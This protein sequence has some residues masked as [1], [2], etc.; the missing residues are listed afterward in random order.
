[1]L[2]A[3]RARDVTA[4]EA[5]LLAAGVPLMATAVRALGTAVAGLLRQRCGRVVGTSVAVLVG[6][7][8]NGADA[9]LAGAELAR[10]GVAVIAI[11]AGSR[12]HDGAARAAHRTGITLLAPGAA[13]LA[14]AA[15]CDVVLD[16]VTGIGADGPLRGAGLDVVVGL[17]AALEA[18]PRPDRPLV[19][20]VDVP[21]GIGVDD[22][23]VAG[24][25]LGADR[26]ITMGTAKPGLLLPPAAL[27]AGE[28]D[29]VDLGLDLAGAEPAVVR[30]E[31]ADV[32]R[33][34]PVPGPTDHK[35]TRGVLGVV[36][37][38][39][40]YPGA[41][42]LATSAAA[43]LVGM[44]RFLGPDTVVDAVLARHPEV[45]HGDGRAQA[46]LVGPGIG[47]DDG[48]RL[49]QVREVLE[50]AV[51]HGLPAVVDA[52]A[53]EVL[54]ERVGAQV[55]L[56]PHAGE[57]A[58][59]L[60]ARGE[61]VAREDVEARPLA[62]LR[63]AVALTGATVLLKGAVTLVAGPGTA[64]HSQADGTAWLATAGAGDVLAGVVGAALAVR[65][66]DVVAEPGLAAPLAA[67][68]AAVHGRAARRASGGGPIVAGDVARAVAATLAEVLRD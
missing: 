64:V 51:A 2:I 29:V 60:G 28:V 56:T 34:W 62:H 24:P 40:G 33:L 3:R 38:S 20:A 10:R 35:Y 47:V 15:R 48:E 14:R 68:A 6:S 49:A 54:P 55:V 61:D 63:R 8:D 52:G 26:T 30:L 12:V 23:T 31:R 41:A 1:M 36:A 66:D 18:V 53:L 17:L 21:S 25:V 50:R 65:S 37:G 4:A 46:W 42:V 13:A 67:A 58:R 9:L 11:R 43:P 16:G 5:P 19:V 7:G 57:L 22:G 59:L 39:T 45:V 44:V 32:A 27:L